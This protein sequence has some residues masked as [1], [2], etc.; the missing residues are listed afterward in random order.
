MWHLSLQEIDII[1][2]HREKQRALQEITEKRERE[3]HDVCKRV[4]ER[5]CDAETENGD[6]TF[7][8]NFTKNELA[9]CIEYLRANRILV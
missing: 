3:R 2:E 1:K 7:I 4:Y 9:M 6:E 8:E 5:F